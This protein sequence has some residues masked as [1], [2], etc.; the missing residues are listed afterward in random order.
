[1]VNMNKKEHEQ[2]K[3]TALKFLALG[4]FKVTPEVLSVKAM[5]QRNYRAGLRKAAKV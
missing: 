4:K 2:F 3:A 5:A 1:M